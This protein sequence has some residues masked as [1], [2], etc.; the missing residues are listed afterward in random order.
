MRGTTAIRW[1]VLPDGRSVRLFRLRNTA[2][3]E[4]DVSEYGAALVRLT[5]PDR[6]GRFDDVVLGFDSLAGYLGGNPS[7]FGVMVGRCAGR[8]AGARFMLD[9]NEILLPANDGRNHLHGGPTGFSR[10]LWSG[11]AGDPTGE[12]SVHMHLESPDGDDGYPGRLAVDLVYTLGDTGELELRWSAVADAPTPVNLTNHSYFNLAGGG[13]VLAHRIAIASDAFLPVGEGLIP[14]GEV[15]PVEGSAFDLRQPTVVGDILSRDDA[16]VSAAGGVDHTWVLGTRSSSP[17]HAAEVR[18]PHGG[19]TLHISTTEPGLVL[20]TGNFLDGTE[21]GKNGTPCVRHA[22]LCLEAQHFP[23][24]PNRPSFPSVIL[25]P[26]GR[27]SS[28]TVYRFGLS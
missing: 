4:A 5:A 28:V 27:R 22:G 19:R 2:G 16:Q 7:F 14:T 15:R 26:G 9:G 10:K 25:R 20:Y 8:I 24:S 21:R 3:M 6:N 18:D 12:A 11:T 23:D 1:G 17:V 13:D